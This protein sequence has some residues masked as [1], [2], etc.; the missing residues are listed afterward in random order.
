MSFLEKLKQNTEIK[1]PSAKDLGSKEENPKKK[2]KIKNL[3]KLPPQ[4]E[5]EGQLFIDVYET[6]EELVIQSTIAGVMAEDIDIS[7]ENE[8]ITIRG[9]RKRPEEKIESYFH[10][11]CYWGPFSRQLILPTEVDISRA[12]ASMK[13]GVFTLRLPKVERKRKK[14]IAVK[15]EE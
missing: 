1:E 2:K 12:E 11:E 8:M 5:F 9:S 13:D 4:E 3:K 10:Q 6:N 14:K 7:I 15:E